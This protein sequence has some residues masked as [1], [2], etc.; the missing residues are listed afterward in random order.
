MLGLGCALLVLAMLATPHRAQDDYPLFT[1]PL[2]FLPRRQRWL[3]A[4]AV[5]LS[6][7]FP[8]TFELGWASSLQLTLFTVAPAILACALVRGDWPQAA[9][10]QPAE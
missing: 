10:L 2:L 9:V 1:L 4:V 6:W 8:L 7:A 3:V 5:G